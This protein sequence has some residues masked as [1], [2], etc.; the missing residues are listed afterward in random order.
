MIISTTIID[1][2]C[3]NITIIILLNFYGESRGTIVGLVLRIRIVR[4][5]SN[6][7]VYSR[8]LAIL[9]TI[10]KVVLVKGLE[11]RRLW[12]EQVMF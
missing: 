1:Y 11:F 7:K 4:A 2:I 10:L 3:K 5:G 12:Y 9:N 6:R 8:S